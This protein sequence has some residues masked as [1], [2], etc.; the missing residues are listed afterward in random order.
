MS[1]TTWIGAPVDRVDGR[2]KVTGAAPYSGDVDLPR[3]AHAVLVLSTIANGRIT[4][5]DIATAERMPGVLAILT[6]MNAWKLPQGGRAGVNPPAGRV[7]TLLQDD[8][9]H[10]NRQPIGVVVAETLD[11]AAAAARM[12]KVAYAAKPATLNFAEAKPNAHAPEKANQEPTDSERGLIPAEAFARV[13]AIYT[14]PM[15]HHNP[16]EPHATVAQWQGERLTLYDATQY[17]SGCQTTV[18]KTLGIAKENVRVVCPYLGGGFG[19]KGSTWAHVPLAAMAARQVARPV[20]LVLERPQMFGPVGGRPQT[21]Q[22][23][24]ISAD[25]AHRLTGTR[26]DVFSHTSM[27]EDFTEPAALQTRMQYACPNVKTAHRL[28]RLS[29]GTPTFQR[30][31]GEA[32]GTFALESAI[33]E[34]AYRLKVD[35]LELRRRN[36]PRIDEDKQ[37][38]WSSR[39]LLEC[40]RQGAEA[41][42]WSSRNPEPRSTTAG[43]LRV[44]LGMA[45]ATYPANRSPASASARLTSDGLL[46]VR[47]GTQELGTGMYTVMTQ[48]AAETLGFPLD[49]VRFELGDSRYPEAPVSGGSQSTASVAPAVQSAVALLRDKLVAMAI[50]DPASPVFGASTEEVV[51]EAARIGR[52]DRGAREPVVATLA[53]GGGHPLETEASAK[54]GDEKKQYSLHSF[55]A[56][57]AEVNVDPD[58]GVIRVPRVVARYDV[59]TLLNAK[60]GRSQLMGG[61]VMGIGMALMEQSVLDERYGRIVNANLAEYHVPTNAD[62]GTI[63]VAVVDDRDPYINPLGARGIGEI[64]I[65]GVAGAIANAVYHATGVRVRDLPITLDKLLG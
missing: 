32:P 43:R 39:K 42:R 5:L 27:I 45:T 25:D 38:P 52:R 24:M 8:V 30:A 47:S 62:V 63:D 29:V 11:Q 20:K 35:P 64:G 28:V 34:L 51:I 50:A 36:E 23:V 40:Y 56:V 14:T 19:C 13:E 57:F 49:R 12:V 1:D 16:M 41:F 2:L 17:I 58:L 61:V 46:V 22:H 54:P 53:R 15:E 59:G 26:H 44:G 4:T 55:G 3:L 10:F 33:D 6:H 60:T 21:E 48:I 65:T 31:P 37:L 18:A 7:L 9:V